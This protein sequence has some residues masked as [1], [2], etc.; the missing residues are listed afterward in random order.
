MITFTPNPAPVPV[1]P[2]RVPFNRLSLTPT[3]VFRMQARQS[4]K[5]TCYLKWQSSEGSLNTNAEEPIDAAADLA[6][7]LPPQVRD[8]NT[9]KHFEKITLGKVIIIKVHS[10]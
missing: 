7:P 8:D 9:L 6:S 5:H 4:C 3:H 1:P 10:G 2:D